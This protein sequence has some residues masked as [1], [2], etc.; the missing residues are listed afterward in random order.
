MATNNIKSS[1]FSVMNYQTSGLSGLVSGMDTDSMVKKML[2]GTQKRIDKQQALKQQALWRQIM[3]RDV[4]STINSLQKKF[5]N[6]SVDASPLN[7]LASTKFWNMK[8]SLITSGSSVK[9]LSTAYTATTGDM[10]IDVKQLATAATLT[11]RKPVLEDSSITASKSISEEM[12]LAFDKYLSIRVDGFSDINVDLNGVQNQEEMLSRF[13][14]KF[15]NAT[16]IPGNVAN[17]DTGIRAEIK[18]G[19]LVFTNTGAATVRVAGGS[20]LGQRMTG[21]RVGQSGS[22]TSAGSTLITGSSD[23]NPGAGVTFRV[24]L[25]GIEKQVTLNPTVGEDGVMTLEDV[26]RGLQEALDLT[27]G[28]Y[29]MVSLVGDE[30]GKEDKLKLSLIPELGAGSSLTIYDTDAAMLGLTPGSTNRVNTSAKLS[31]LGV[32]GEKFAFSINGIRFNFTKDDTI[33]DMINTINTSGA[34]VTMNFS[35]VTNVFSLTAKTTGSKVDITI[36]QTDGDLL[37][38]LFKQADGTALIGNAWQTQTATSVD[39]IGAAGSITGGAG[40]SALDYKFEKGA[41]FTIKVNGQ[42]YTFSL[43]GDE[44]MEGEE[45]SFETVFNALESWIE[46][47]DGLSGKIRFRTVGVDNDDDGTDDD[48]IFYLD[49]LGGSTFS[50]EMT[51]EDPEKNIA[52]ALGFSTANNTNSVDV[53]GSTRLEDVFFSG[54]GGARFSLKEVVDEIKTAFVGALPAGINMDNLLTI[55][56]LQN[57]STGL[58]EWVQF[59]G[60]RLTLTP[61]ANSGAIPLATGPLAAESKVSQLFGGVTELK[62]ETGSSSLSPAD[63]TAGK[64]A[65]FTIDGAEVTRA[66]NVVDVNGVS[67]QLVQT[68]ITEITTSRDTESIF[69]SI[70]AFVDEYNA[71]ISKLNGYITAEPTFRDYAPLTAEQKKEMTEREIE[72]WEEQ[73]KG[74]LLR[75]DLN[76]TPFLNSIFAATYKKPASSPYALY[77]IGIEA[78]DYKQPGILFI[79]EARLREMLEQDPAGVEALFLDPTGGLAVTMTEVMDRY[80]KESSADPGYLV[81]LAGAPGTMLDKENE[82]T[83]AIQRINDRLKDLE[84]KY[85]KERERYWAKFNAM[86]RVMAQYMAMM[87]QL[88]SFSVNNM[89]SY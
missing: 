8:S 26:R 21:L 39:L 52:W 87:E 29:I 6:K 62:Y 65:I 66:N 81:S 64:D 19:R 33:G 78:T 49:S 77:D 89:S 82:I 15:Q 53:A 50:I 43:Q 27:F 86:E 46:T 58:G 7:N 4:I 63:Y 56:D 79:N 23:V 60:G 55:D 9:L 68:G 57:T 14:D 38:V 88:A 71:V 75:N 32:S 31:E 59:A 10:T 84:D 16:T 85:K 47:T 70:K 74:G 11:S 67:L 42:N 35:S 73:A 22:A 1:T 34:G 61:T 76:I 69:N 13:N 54:K 28:K 80:A 48:F 24:N 3:Y 30:V 5:F 25:D 51:E 2:E 40:S 41:A 37:G 12:L 17:Q 20:N 72:L 36:E 44:W 83:N 18:N 45:Y